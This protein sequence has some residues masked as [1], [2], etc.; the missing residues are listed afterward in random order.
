MLSIIFWQVAKGDLPMA[1]RL[2]RMSM[3]PNYKLALPSLRSINS[4]AKIV[5]YRNSLGLRI[6]FSH[7]QVLDCG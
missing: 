3:T 2:N 1:L 4:I 7:N 5:T 6:G